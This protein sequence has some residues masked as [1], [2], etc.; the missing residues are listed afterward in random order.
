MG[1]LFFLGCF[2]TGYGQNRVTIRVVDA[3]SEQ[4]LAGVRALNQTDSAQGITNAGGYLELPASVGDSIVL[5]AVDYEMG[6]LVAPENATF[7]ARLNRVEEALEFEGGIKAF[8]E[9]IGRAMKYPRSAR[10]RQLQGL[11][12]V[13]FSIDEQGKMADITSS[14]S[15]HPGFN[16]EVERVLSNI[17]G[18]WSSAYQGKRMTLP[19]VFAIGA[20]PAVEI[21][22]EDIPPN[23]RVLGEVVVV[24]YQERHVR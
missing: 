16:R 24:A 3:L 12:L 2:L 10:S 5:T 23:S 19:V 11:V 1:V 20:K 15:Q 6:V 22:D 9:Q 13:S 18:T 17:K 8:Y 14:A 21:S 7:Q 4:A